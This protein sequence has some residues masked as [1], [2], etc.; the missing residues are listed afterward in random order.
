MPRYIFF[1]FRASDLGQTPLHA[2]CYRG[3]IKS[4]SALVERG[5]DF[6]F[7][8]KD[9]RTAKDWAMLNP[10]AKKRQLMTEYIVKTR[11]FAMTHSGRDVLLERQSSVYMRRLEYWTLLYSTSLDLQ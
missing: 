6:R 8:D 7:H 2:A 11:M 10:N 5:G 3:C 4:V 9:Q 1:I